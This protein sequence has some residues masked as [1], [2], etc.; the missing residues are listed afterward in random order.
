MHRLLTILIFV[1]VSLPAA[2]GCRCTEPTTK[3][4]YARAEAVARVRIVEVSEPTSDGTVTA[5]GEVESAWKAGLPSR[6][7]IITGEDCAYPFESGHTYLLF[8][9]KGEQEWGTYR[10]R[11]NKTD[12]E[13]AQAVRWLKRYGTAQPVDPDSGSAPQREKHD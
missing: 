5:Q 11:G 1:V 2:F 8:L 7:R 4:A 9:F 3:R 12:A 10:C 6:I 13:S